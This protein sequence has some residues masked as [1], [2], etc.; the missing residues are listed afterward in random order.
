MNNL[1]PVPDQFNF[2]EPEA[3]EIWRKRFV[4]YLT[5]SGMNEKTELEKIDMLL[6]IMGPKS[7]AIMLQIKEKPATVE[8]TL[9]EFDNY[10]E[11]K[12]NVIFERYKFNTRKQNA[13]E[14]IDA[15]ITVLYSMAEKCKYGELKEE[16]LRDRIVV[17]MLDVKA[18][19]FM[20]LK[21]DLTLEKAIEIAKQCE[22]QTI[23]NK[24]I[25]N[26]ESSPI[27]FVSVNGN[28]KP[29]YNRQ[30]FNS[31]QGN[32]S[33]ICYF[34]AK[35]FH[36]RDI[37]PARNANCL[38]CGLK[39]HFRKACKSSKNINSGK[40]SSNVNKNRNVN[41]IDCEREGDNIQD[42]N[43]ELFIGH[44][45]GHESFGIKKWIVR[46]RIG[47]FN[48]NVDFLIDT[49]ASNISIPENLVP[50]K[51]MGKLNSSSHASGPD[52]TP[53]AVLGSLSLTIVY[54]N[55][56]KICLVYVIKNL[57]TPLLGREAI[58]LFNMVQP[59]YSQI[60]VNNTD[61]FDH[62]MSSDILQQY[63]TIFDEIGEFKEGVSI[64]LK[65]DVTP[66]VQSVPRP[67][68]I[69]LM[70]KL[71]A[72]LD[73]LLRL[74]I[75][76]PMH[77]VTDWVSPIVVVKK[78]ENE[79]RLCVDYTKLNL[80]ICRPY[81]PIPRIE[82]TLANLQGAKYFSKIDINKGFYQIKLNK[83]SQLLTC[84][85]T[86]FGRYIFTRLPFGISCAPEYFV[87]KYAQVLRDIQ[88]IASHVDDV[89]I[90]GK[91]KEEHDKALQLVLKRLSDEGITI[92]RSKSV[93]CVKKV[94]WLGHILSAEGVAI[95]PERVEAIRKYDV[96]QNRNQLLRFLGIVNF[97]GKFIQNKSSILEPLNNLLKA[98]VNFQWNEIHDKAFEE[99]KNKMC[100]TP[101]LAYYNPSKQI[102]ISA[103]ASS[104][105]IGG[106]LIQQ[107]E[108]GNREI[109]AYTSRTMT[110]TERYYA[111]IEREALGL[112]WAAEK[113]SDYITGLRVILE[114]DHKPLLQILQSK[115]LDVLTP[116]L[117][118]FRMRLMRYD[119]VVEYVPGKL[120][121]VADAL[122]RSPIENTGKNEELT[123]Q[124]ENYVNHVTSCLPVKDTYLKKIIDAQLEDEI[125]QILRQYVVDGWP[126][127]H[128]IN[129]K[130]LP[131]YQHRFEF[132]CSEGLLLKGCR[133][134]IPLSLQKEVIEF[135]HAGHQ[136]ITK[137]RRRAQLSVWWVGL[138]TQL[139]NT[140][141]NCPNCVESR[142]NIKEPFYRE[143]F[144]TR[145]MEKV[146]V[147]F[148][149]IKEWYIII[150]DYYS[151]YFE[152]FKVTSMT[153]DVLISKLK[154]YFS[155]FGLCDVLRSDS[156]SQFL[157][158]KFK[159]FALKCNFI[160][161]TSSP[162]YHQANGVAE[163]AVNTAKRLIGKNDDID[164]ALLSYRATPLENGFSPAELMLGRR[165]KTNVPVIPNLLK[166]AKGNQV[167]AIENKL[168]D[169]SEFYYNKR[170]KVKELTKLK[171]GDNVWI[172]D[173]KIYGVI[174]KQLSEPRSYL[175][176]TERGIFRRN[177]WH[178]IEASY[179]KLESSIVQTHP[180]QNYN[181]ALIMD[182]NYITKNNSLID[183]NTNLPNTSKIESNL[184]ENNDN[185][186]SSFSSSSDDGIVVNDIDRP[187]NTEMLSNS[188]YSSDVNSNNS[189]TRRSSRI[190]NRPKWMADYTFDLSK[191]D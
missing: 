8:L 164:L 77:D 4:R 27:N 52:G 177:R 88:N 126:K 149:K 133:I 71:K 66:F 191:I 134:V 170:H 188:S 157:G 32:F 42:S 131:Y 122:S 101:V 178:L 169:K 150:T 128:L 95:D 59:P 60:E 114:T 137:C 89:L 96:P 5:L 50:L 3:W 100:E 53:L 130:I 86:P 135:I 139:E 140:I 19:E 141:K 142:T 160:I 57:K 175:V 156:G 74:Q 107:D 83:E 117:Q 90:Y 68:P 35:P 84:F 102:I 103:D 49:G 37:C 16:L 168:K 115:N 2:D 14:S 186:I 1:I 116:R 111:Q 179:K 75:I 118:R 124:V 41:V 80:F 30:Q 26:N 48:S 171:K 146:A 54:N 39:G 81:Y 87:A 144:P 76:E 6:Y 40:L 61:C 22:R 94:K 163:A 93:F 29:D 132:S 151:R 18:S 85:I 12:T 136:G 138:S 28:K 104:Y 127:K 181:A 190:I 31:P 9:Q 143:H 119:Y 11:P 34:C 105:G 109:V 120:L 45:M 98:D 112:T 159:D 24:V 185:E 172:V 78:N 7:E 92:N 97:V 161:E 70:K 67:V 182:E 72:E 15:Y 13:N 166:V 63:P 10:F 25:R 99:I 176:Q 152:I 148:F 58:D 123:I 38:K 73:R 46:C 165:I 36:N 187:E 167:A 79:I 65:K 56:S 158:A 64:K 125:C 106:C 21:A 154:Q 62:Q 147:D 43:Y 55:M 129:N 23:E 174:V 189:P 44:V 121:I 155:R 113:F 180:N 108:S 183:V 51:Y 110:Q 82:M 153:E 69:P 17:G 47:E 162:H 20:Q 173:L 91:T 184:L 33:K 145:P